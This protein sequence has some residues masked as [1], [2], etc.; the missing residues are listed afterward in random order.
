MVYDGKPV[1]RL[2]VGDIPYLPGGIG[3]TLQNCRPQLRAY[4]VRAEADA[5]RLMQGLDPDGGRAHRK[6]AGAEHRLTSE[7]RVRAG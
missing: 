4:R 3:A 5:V 1:S 7:R 2:S 6:L